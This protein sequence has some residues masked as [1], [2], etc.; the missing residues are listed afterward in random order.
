MHIHA[1]RWHYAGLS[2]YGSGATAQQ[3][4]IC[5]F[6]GGYTSLLKEEPSDLTYETLSTCKLYCIDFN[7]FTALSKD[8]I[9][10]ANLYIKVLQKIFI[11]Y[12]QRSLDLM[13]LNATDRY[14]KLQRQIPEIDRLIPQYQI[15]SYL[16]ITPVQLSRI[17]KRLA[18]EGHR[19]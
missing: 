4:N 14:L 15:A 16:G 9:E 17:R 11:E 18:A 19:H 7:A 1:G 10:V 8:N 12:E 2:H 5:A 13:S 3:E 6:V